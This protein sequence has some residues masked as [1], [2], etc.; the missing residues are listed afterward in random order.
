[1]RRTLLAVLLAIVTLLFVSCDQVTNSEPKP[2]EF[3]TAP[4]EGLSTMIQETPSDFTWGYFQDNVQVNMTQGTDWSGEMVISGFKVE[5]G[6]VLNRTTTGPITTNA[7]ELSAGLSTEELFS[8]S[9]WFSGSKWIPASEWGPSKL[10]IPLMD[11]SLSK[12]E[13]MAIGNTDLSEDQTMIVVYAK[14][15]GDTDREVTTQPFGVI[16]DDTDI[17]H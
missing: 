13:N 5:G 1:M 6:E 12:V 9:E 17:V 11:R 8:G 15:A 14:V 4:S 3:Q 10:W 16:F 7:D 2:L